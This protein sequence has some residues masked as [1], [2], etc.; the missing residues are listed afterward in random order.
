[1]YDESFR[2][3][4]LVCWPGVVK[5]GAVNSDLVSNLDFAQTFLAIAGVDNPADMQ[6]RSLL[7]ILKGQTPDDWRDSLYYHYYEYPGWHMVHRHEGVYD[8]R[9]KL[10]NFYDLE[11]WELYDLETDPKEMT[12]QYHNPEYA[13]V[14]M[15][16]HRKLDDLRRQYRVPENV[17]QDPDTVDRSYH[18]AEQLKRALKKKN[19]Q[20]K[21]AD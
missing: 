1:M 15:T 21:Q 3:P 6:G 12:N 17:K 7:P 20:K 16:L 11:E 9:Y 8:G 5:P 2:T 10:I 14:V 4:L 13:E 18:S 19:T